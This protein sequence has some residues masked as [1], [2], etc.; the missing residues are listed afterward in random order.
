VEP[1]G[2]LAQRV[3]L[4]VEQPDRPA[5]RIGFGGDVRARHRIDTGDG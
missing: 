1:G 5:E 4:I 3:D 2:A